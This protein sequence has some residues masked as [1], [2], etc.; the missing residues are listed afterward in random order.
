MEFSEESLPIGCCATSTSKT[1][2]IYR[3]IF[4]PAGWR[5]WFVTGLLPLRSWVRPR[6]KSLGFPD[7]EKRQRPSRMKKQ[8]VKDPMS[9]CP[10]WMLS[11]KLNPSTDKI[12]YRAVIKYLFL[13]VNTPTQIKYE[14]YFVY[15][16]S[17]PSFTKVK[18]WAAE[19]KRSR[20]SLGDEERSGRPSTVTND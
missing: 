7:T 1:F 20:M 9:V 16:D 2:N 19:F 14:L 13:K 10:A 6:L 5:G 15:G 18:C 17:A 11:A 12:E 4:K 3:P 8:H